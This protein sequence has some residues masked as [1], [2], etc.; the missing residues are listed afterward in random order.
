[1]TVIGLAAIVNL[2]AAEPMSVRMALSEMERWPTAAHL[3]F[4]EGRLKWNYTTGFELDALLDVH[5]RYGYPAMQEYALEWADAI[6]DEK[7]NITT[8]KT[9]SY[10]LDHI[11]PGGPLL[12][13]YD[14]TGDVKFRRASRLLRA[15]LDAQPRTAGGGFWH[16]QIY[17][18][19]MWLD[20]LF[21]ASPW[22]AEYASRWERGDEQ[23][24]SMADIARQFT[25]VAGHTFDPATRLY[26]HAWDES[27]SMF[28][29]DPQTG[30]SAHAWGRALGWYVMAIVDALD[31]VPENTPGRDRMVEI[32]QGIYRELPRWAD[33]AT[34]MWYQVLD[35]PGREGNYVEATA[36]AMFSYA[37]LKGIRQGY[38]DGALTP[39]A[40]ETYE[41]L[42]KTFI[43][44]DPDGTI[45]LE[46]CCA[47]AGLG[48]AQMRSGTFEYYISE[49]VRDNDPK[50]TAAFMRA[51]LEYE[52]LKNIDFDPHAEEIRP[53]A[54]PGAGGGGKYA[55]G[56]RGGRVVY[57][58]SLADDGSEGTLR[59]ALEQEGPRTVLFKVSG[60]IF[61]RDRRVI[62]N[63]DLTVAGQSAPGDGICVAGNFVTVG[64]DNIIIRYMRFRMGDTGGVEGDAFNGKGGESVII[65]PCSVSWST[66][67]CASVYAMR[68]F[69]MQWCIVSEA[70]NSSLHAK[71]DH[72]YGAIWGGRNATFH[73]NLFAHNNSR[74]PRLDHPAI[75]QRNQ[76]LTHRGTVEFVNNVVY[77]W[78]NTA[79]YG[80]ERGWWNFENNYFKAG[81]ASKNPHRQFTEVSVSP[82]T[83]MTPGR[84]YIAGNV[85]EG[86]PEINADN[87]RGVLLDGDFTR[88]DVDNVERFP[89][90]AAVPGEDAAAAYERVLAG[91]GASHRRDA[92]DTRIISEV[93][94]GT[95]TYTGSVNG[96]PG[97]IDSQ[98]DVGGWPELR[99]GKAP[100]DTDGDGMPDKWEK[101]HRLDLRDPSDGARLSADG[102][103]TNLEIYI[104]GI[105][106]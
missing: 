78:G 26:R 56:G 30:Q 77:N 59:H 20:G 98:N 99:G 32:L 73:H 79:S 54:F 28:W 48:G 103:F 101:R 104:N 60:T 25:V 46:K 96:R 97:I 45:S 17:P 72:G 71:G 12:R 58:T 7:G 80:G 85:L 44:E 24:A 35:Q 21:M 86:A 33:P 63:G 105:V 66:D 37:L 87:W 106:E 9:E 41:N 19:Q 95:A 2:R 47:V 57:V 16:K 94:T 83:S 36:S 18:H 8:Y 55:T 69:T 61:L 10:N 49:P 11:R 27:R 51:S 100:E 29:A 22:Y 34:G 88:G 39:W 52:A 5:D 82:T 53:V 14:R 23:A 50:G 64:A 13:L 92:V 4:M 75:Y 40:V 91:A 67:E 70:L 1:M 89:V 74:N 3:D 76:L 65:D 38:L 93:R 62:R 68:N 90:F 15:Q 31:W 42:V 102:Q 81:P 84:Y 43:R 6:I